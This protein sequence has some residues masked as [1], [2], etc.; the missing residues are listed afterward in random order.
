MVSRKCARSTIEKTK[1]LVQME[2]IIVPRPVAPLAPLVNAVVV[3]VVLVLNLR[4]FA[5]ALCL[6]FNVLFE[7]LLLGPVLRT[8]LSLA[9]SLYT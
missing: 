1:P 3:L 7:F 8:V 5:L 2:L 6:A 9:V 4:F